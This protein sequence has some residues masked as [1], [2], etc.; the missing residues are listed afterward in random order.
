MS[1]KVFEWVW[2]ALLI[3]I[4][5]VRTLHERAAGGNQG[6]KGTPLLEA[7]LMVMWAMAAAVI[8]L[9]YMFSPWLRLADYP[10]EI[11]FTLGIMGV[12][13]FVAAIRLLHRSHADLGRS[14]STNVRPNEAHRLVVDGVYRRTRHP[15]YSAHILWGIAQGL[16]LPNFLAGPLALILI[17]VLVSIRVPREERLLL[18]AFSDQ[19]RQ[20]MN[21]TGRFLPRF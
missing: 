15:M 7:V 5:T 19:Y 12:G 8:P 17:L 18:E 2:F 21:T 1:S 9:L 4:I 11:P 10:F 14:W 3:A 6:I 20:Y 13:I 16:L